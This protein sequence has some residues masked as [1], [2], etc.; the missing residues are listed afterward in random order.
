MLQNLKILDALGQEVVA[1]SD[2]LAVNGHKA[3]VHDN[4]GA[5]LLDVDNQLAAVLGHEITG[6]SHLVPFGHIL[7]QHGVVLNAGRHEVVA[8]GNDFIAALELDVHDNVGADLLDVD[9]QLA[10]VLGHEITGHSHLVPFG[11]ILLQ[12][13]VVLN[14]GRHEVVAAGNKGTISGLEG[15]VHDDVGIGHNL[16]NADLQLTVLLSHEVAGHGHPIA[17][18]H[19]LLQHGVILHSGRHK[20][21]AAGND[22]ITALKLDVHNNCFRGNLLDVDKQRCVSPCHKVAGRGH[23]VSFGHILL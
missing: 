10:A 13:G 12:H 20:V 17:S 7:L 4:V 21:I 18:R 2:E 23:L 5:D 6:H 3:D 11:H 16:L 19:I 22:F 1:A 14:A 8:A 9:N 15:N